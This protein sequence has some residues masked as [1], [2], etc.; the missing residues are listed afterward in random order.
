MSD[1]KTKAPPTLDELTAFLTELWYDR[2]PT[3]KRNIVKARYCKE[4]GTLLEKEYELS[5]CD[6]P[7]CGSCS[8][9][10]KVIEDTIK[11]NKR[12]FQLL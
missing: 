2:L 10:R 7:E 3:S 9:Y 12:Q 6:N 5:L 8:I 1:K 4:Q 11:E